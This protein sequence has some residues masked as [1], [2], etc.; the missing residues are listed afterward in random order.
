VIGDPGWRARF[1]AALAGLLERYDVPMLEGWIDAWA[2]QIAA[3]VA[4]DPHRPFTLAEHAA[5]VAALRAAVG[6]RAQYLRA[7]LACERGE[8]PDGT[9]GCDGAPSAPCSSN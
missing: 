4:R 9:E 3:A 2:A 7:F 5:A 6:D 8:G 1:M